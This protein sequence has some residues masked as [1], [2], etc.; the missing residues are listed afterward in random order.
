MKTIRVKLQFT[1]KVTQTETGYVCVDV[2]EDATIADV[3]RSA[4]MKEFVEYLPKSTKVH[5]EDWDFLMES[6]TNGR[7][8]EPA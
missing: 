3:Y 6:P 1:R 2:P 4:F 7:T 5:E 8:K